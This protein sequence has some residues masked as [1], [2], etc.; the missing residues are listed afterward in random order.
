[1]FNSYHV[2]LK[3]TNKIFSSQLKMRA[4]LAIIRVV[5]VESGKERRPSHE[6]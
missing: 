1:M 4:L 3:K 5:D 2:E 6:K